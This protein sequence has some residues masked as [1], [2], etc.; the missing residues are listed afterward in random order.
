M[1]RSSHH[2][3]L[4]T[5]LYQV[6][7]PKH[8]RAQSNM[9]QTPLSGKSYS[10]ST[11]MT[12]FLKTSKS[13]Q[14]TFNT[15]LFHVNFCCQKSLESSDVAW[16]YLF[17]S[18][19]A[20]DKCCVKYILRMDSLHTYWNWYQYVGDYTIT[21]NLTILWQML[22]WIRTSMQ[23]TFLQKVPLIKILLVCIRVT[24]YPC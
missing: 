8:K 20:I 2:L 23:H 24:P 18:N 3:F 21:I 10:F 16:G 5:K 9:H 19:L 11:L 12:Y 22:K 4:M 15:V 17:S 13:I 14:S 6:L 7:K 1:N